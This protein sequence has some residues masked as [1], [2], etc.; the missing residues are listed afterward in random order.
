MGRAMTM[1]ML[2]N[3]QNNGNNGGENRRSNYDTYD[4]Y[5]RQNG[6]YNAN[7]DGMENRR[8]YTARNEHDKYADDV[9]EMR[10]RMG[11][12][13][14]EMRRRRDKR[15]RYMEN[16]TGLRAG[17]YDGGNAGFGN[18]Y[19]EP[20]NEA[21]HEN[22]RQQVTAGG[23]FWMNPVGDDD[24]ELDKET[25]YKWVKRMKDS[26]DEPIKPWTEDEIKP[27]ARRFGYPI[28][29]E[30]FENFYT[31]IHAMKSDYCDVA[32]EFDV[33]TPAFYAALADA[34]LSDP[35][36]K[37]KDRKKLEAYYKYI[38]MGKK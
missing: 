26:K 27:L 11:D 30:E 10:R 22:K 37:L 31:A 1:M 4:N 32:E 34:F 13:M 15:G 38:V 3:R 14:P 2:S 33:D 24:D 25:M 8:V 18:R 19:E 5:N 6:A 9:P 7:Y 16:D 17:L 12:D 20:R 23:T 36:A 28:S 21:G 29:G 35:D